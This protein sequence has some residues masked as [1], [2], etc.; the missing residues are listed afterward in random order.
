[1]DE[2]IYEEFK[3]TGNSELHLDRRLS[4]RRIFPA[5]DIKRSGTRREDLLLTPEELRKQHVLR[6]T[7]DAG[8]TSE[9][10]EFLTNRM[11]RTKSNAEF[12]MAISDS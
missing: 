9:V 8:E 6:K 10:T 12:L 2:V 1:M 7:L 3:G 5:L 11:S 4:D